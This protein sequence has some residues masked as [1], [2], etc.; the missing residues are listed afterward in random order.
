MIG[1]IN[2]VFQL[3]QL[4]TTIGGNNA[5]FIFMTNIRQ[6]VAPI[7]VIAVS[8]AVFITSLNRL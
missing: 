5:T 1:L 8:L 7:V 6:F 4:P 3:E 2:A